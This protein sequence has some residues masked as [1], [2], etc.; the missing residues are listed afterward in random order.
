MDDGED[1]AYGID[2]KE[3]YDIELGGGSAADDH[4]RLAAGSPG[5][6]GRTHREIEVDD[7]APPQG[8]RN[9]WMTFFLARA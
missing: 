5:A 6:M 9:T 3:G 1:D 4:D 2:S 7:L 8:D